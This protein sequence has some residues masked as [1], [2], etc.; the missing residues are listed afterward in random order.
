MTITAGYELASAD[1]DLK[2]RTTEHPHYPKG[3]DICAFNG[4]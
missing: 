4:I 1:A 3:E 2:V